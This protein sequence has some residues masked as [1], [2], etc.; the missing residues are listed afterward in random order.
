MRDVDLD[1]LA[2]IL[3]LLDGLE[4][5]EVRIEAPDL[6]VT[7]RRGDLPPIAGEPPS[8]PPAAREPS[9]PARPAPVD[10]GAP[11]AVPVLADTAVR[12]TAPMLGTF[13]RA[14]KPGDAPFVEV[15][16]RVEPGTVLCIIEV[17]KLMNSV[18]AE[19]S[20]TVTDIC[21]ANGALVEYDQVLFAIRPEEG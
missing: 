4:F 21:A 15:G 8:A 13:Y 17:M 9:R 3:E 7:V 16:D 19:V 5:S 11:A 10:R 1:D 14:E 18:Q 2:A 6:T 20:G 12:V